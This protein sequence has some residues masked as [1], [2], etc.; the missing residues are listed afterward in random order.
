MEPRIHVITLAV[1]DL[2]RAFAFYHDGL[3]LESPGVFG[4]EFVGDETNPDG[5][6]AM[7]HLEGA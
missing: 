4:A 5:T 1:S 6:V 2:H 3:G 7:F